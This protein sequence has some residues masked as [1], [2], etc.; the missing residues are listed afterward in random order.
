[1]SEPTALQCLPTCTEPVTTTV[2]GILPTDPPKPACADCHAA[3]WEAMAT[4][5]RY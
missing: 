4:S 2:P 3:F 5:D 1:M